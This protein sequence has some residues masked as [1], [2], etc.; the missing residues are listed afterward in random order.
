MSIKEENGV[1]QMLLP[2]KQI[3]IVTSY[4]G[5]GGSTISLLEL[6]EA[7]TSQGHECFMYGPDQWPR[8]NLFKN[9][10]ELSLNSNDYVIQHLIE[11]PQ[12]PMVKRIIL[13][14]HEKSYFDLNRMNTNGYDAIR[15]VSRSQ[16]EWHGVDGV[17]IPNIFEKGSHIGPVG[18]AG[19]IGSISER[20]QTHVAIESAL[21]DDQQVLV[22]GPFKKSNQNYL[23]EFVMPLLKH[24]RVKYMGLVRDRHRMYSTVSAVYCASKE[25]CAC[26]VRGECLSLGIP[27]HNTGDAL[28][29]EMWS[30]NRII[31]E[32]TR[33]MA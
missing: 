6:C 13:S 4:S 8:S 16:Q 18:V 21:S 27:F 24:P 33:L 28:E 20:K 7:F 12:R 5:F 31:K 19:V 32:W 3:K 22:Y 14:C 15:F 23:D 17:I 30:K 2:S 10:S 26:R 1:L 25:E 29:Y 9:I 11:L